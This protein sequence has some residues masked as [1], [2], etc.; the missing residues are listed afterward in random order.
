M[1]IHDELLCLFSDE[2]EAKD[3]SYTITVPT[4][5]IVDG[6]IQPNATYR[7]AILKQPSSAESTERETAPTKQ[8][9]QKSQVQNHNRQSGH[10]AAPVEEGDRRTVDIDGV[11]EKGD[12]IARIDNGYV[13]IVPDTEKRDRVSVEITNVTPNVAFTEVVE[14]KAYYE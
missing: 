2:V 12:G 13:L 10:S 11:G 14:H 8:R 7:V 1:E 6:D 5:E 9:N 4:R 3:G